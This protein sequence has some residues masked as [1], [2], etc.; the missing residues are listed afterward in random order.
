MLRYGP[1]V[2]VPRIVDAFRRFNLRQTFF[3]PGWC[4][5]NY[6]R[7]I[8]LIQQNGHEIAHHGYLHERPNW[9]S[10]DQEH[11][12]VRRASNSILKH[13]GI[14]PKGF[15]APSYAFSKNTLDILI[16]EGFSYDASLMGHDIPYLI[17]NGSTALVELPSDMSLDDWTQYVC[18]KDFGNLLPIASP[19]RAIEVFRAEF[20]A[21]WRHGGLWISVWHPFVSGRASRCDAMI[22]LI[23][24]MLAKGDVW[25]AR[26]DDI[27]A[28]VER[29]IKEGHME[30][31]R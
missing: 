26:L 4:V 27:S 13:T 2:A 17:S 29:C 6:P 31:S 8:E 1:E 19:Q 10:K 24:Y 30:T 15:R 28:H 22:S 5:E 12:C 21:M 14:R 11:D 25:F 9:L 7:A 20:D 3:I 18:I 23:E 16:E